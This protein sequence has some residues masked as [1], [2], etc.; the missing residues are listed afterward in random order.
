M[1]VE[2]TTPT[3]ELDGVSRRPHQVREQAA[4]WRRMRRLG[5]DE[6]AGSWAREQARRAWWS[7]IRRQ[8]WLLTRMA[9][10]ATVL[11]T[12]LA[13]VTPDVFARGLVVGVGATAMVT[14]MA[15]L[16][17]QATGTAHLTAGSAA[18]QWT[19][20]ELRQLRAH[21]WR[22]MNHFQL[23]DW[24]ID[25]VL[26]GPGGVIAVETKWSHRDW[27]TQQSRPWLNTAVEQAEANARTLR[28]W[29]RTYGITEVTPVVF[30]W[31]AHQPDRE[32]LPAEPGAIGAT[33][34]V[35]GTTAA[36]AWRQLVTIKSSSDPRLEDEQIGQVWNALDR[37][38][39]RRDL[40]A[41]QTTPPPPTVTRIYWTL[42]GI[43]ASFTTGLLA[44]LNTL[45]AT[46]SWITWAAVT[47]VQAAAGLAA[48]RIAVARRYAA[49]WLIG[50]TCGPLL[51]LIDLAVTRL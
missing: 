8:W 24:D 42:L 30:C 48:L 38:I 37:Q 20:Q 6:R 1:S 4:Q 51:A 3:T 26:V 23:E 10:V 40:T 17:T 11:V 7:F 2:L 41:S 45:T 49:S 46:D 21:G 5:S 43:A 13:W 28:L 25:H 50:T 35:Y 32:K 47:V 39:R 27:R 14:A 33:Q 19:A 44:N 36:T 22:I 18:E 16:T 29:L 31:S 12:G 34:L 9:G 15:L